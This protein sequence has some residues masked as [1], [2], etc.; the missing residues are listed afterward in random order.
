MAD[1]KHSEIRNTITHRYR[2]LSV[3]FVL[4]LSYCPHSNVGKESVLLI[5]AHRLDQMI[6]NNMQKF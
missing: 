2:Y 6:N 3:Y 5:L 1:A 4:S